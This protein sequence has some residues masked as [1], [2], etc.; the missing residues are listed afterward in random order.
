M[1]AHGSGPSFLLHACCLDCGAWTKPWAG[2]HDVCVLD[3]LFLLTPGACQCVDPSA[4]C[5]VPPLGREE[6]WSSVGT[7]KLSQVLLLP[8]FPILLSCGMHSEGLPGGFP[9]ELLK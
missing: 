9:P 8:P 7:T 6:L 4:F 3:T 2:R 1:L 5:W